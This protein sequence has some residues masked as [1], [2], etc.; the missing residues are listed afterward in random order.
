[1]LTIVDAIF[2]S[3]QNVIS[4]YAF[5]CAGDI[6]RAWTRKGVG[7]KRDEVKSIIKVLTGTGI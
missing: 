5:V 6:S 7:G 3:E 4:A 1:M 2:C